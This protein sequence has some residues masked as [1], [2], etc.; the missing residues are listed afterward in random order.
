M[1]SLMSN[2]SAYEAQY[3]A[4]LRE[5]DAIESQIANL[6]LSIQKAKEEESARIAKQRA[7]AEEARRE[8]KRLRERR[9]VQRVAPHRLDRHP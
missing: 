2:L 4:M 1:N 3:D 9:A 7:A 6:D 8:R 5:S